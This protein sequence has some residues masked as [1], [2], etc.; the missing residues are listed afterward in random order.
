MRDDDGVDANV[1]PL[2]AE[3]GRPRASLWR[4][5]LGRPPWPVPWAVLPAAAVVGRRT[6]LITVLS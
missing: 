6:S 5:L 4:L 2:G 1:L 3:P